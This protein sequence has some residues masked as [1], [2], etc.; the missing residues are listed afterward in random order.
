MK[1]IEF[2]NTGLSIAGELSRPGATMEINDNVF[3]TPEEQHEEQGKVF[4]VEVGSQYDTPFMKQRLNV[5]NVDL[6]SNNSELIEPEFNEE[7]E[8][9][10]GF[11]HFDGDDELENMLG[12]EEP[13][14]IV[15]VVKQDEDEGD[16]NE[17]DK[18][19]ETTPVAKTE[20]KPKEKKKT[21]G[22]G[23]KNK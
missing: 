17:G 22:G 1:Q 12:Q 2:V 10:F 11:D 4:Y 5:R 9:N 8:E 13:I 3:M 20:E 6:F 21:R 14:P 19:T 7:G 15:P 18:E 16:E 23:K